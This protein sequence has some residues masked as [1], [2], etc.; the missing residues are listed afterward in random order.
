MNPRRG[1]S[2][3]SSRVKFLTQTRVS[4]LASTLTYPSFVDVAPDQSPAKTVEWT[5]RMTGTIETFDGFTYT[6]KVGCLKR[7][8]T[9]DYDLNSQDVTGGC[10]R[11][12]RTP[13][14]GR[15]AG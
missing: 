3:V 15:E 4:S 13:G 11:G 1:R 9:I 12:I 8:K 7:R 10:S 2:P 6:L 5:I 14:K